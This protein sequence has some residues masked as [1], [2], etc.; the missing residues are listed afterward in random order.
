MSVKEKLVLALDVS[1]EKYALELVDRFKD[2]VEVFKVGFELFVSAGPA[3]VNG[4]NRRGKKVFL[5]LKFHDIPNT[6]EKAARAATRLGIY[7]FNIHTSGGAGMMRRCRDAVEELCI[8]EN[9]RKPIILGVTVLT[10]LS[11][12]ALKSELCIRHSLKTHVKHLSGLAKE[13]GLDG[14]VASGHEVAM[15][16]EHFGKDFIIVAPGIRTSWTPPDDQMR[17]MTPR[18][19]I[20]EGA[21]YIVLGRAVLKQADPFRALELI[22]TEILTA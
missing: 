6:V 2:H 4:I 21:D 14:V 15:I 18:Q 7:M 12:E 8:K 1:E 20:K 9:M 5:D 22:T 16:R 10:G 3:V 19:A 11:P 13:A 17:T